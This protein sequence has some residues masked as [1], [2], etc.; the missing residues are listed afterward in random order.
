MA[1][2]ARLEGSNVVIIEVGP[3]GEVLSAALEGKGLPMG[4]NQASLAAAKQFRFSAD[5][6]CHSTARLVFTFHVFPFCGPAHQSESVDGYEVRTW[7]QGPELA[8]WAYESSSDG[9][10]VCR[11]I[12]EPCP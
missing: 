8:T 12:T 10:M 2:K 1:R 3:N 5:A 7:A 9:S 11:K 6:E 4:L